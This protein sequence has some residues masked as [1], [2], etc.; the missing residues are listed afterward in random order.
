MSFGYQVLGFGTSTAA[1]GPTVEY[2]GGYSAGDASAGSGVQTA[3][4]TKTGD[5]VI[6]MGGNVNAPSG[7]FAQGMTG[8]TV[9][10]IGPAW[11]SIY[12]VYLFGGIRRVA[13]DGEAYPTHTGLQTGQYGVVH[14]R[15]SDP[16]IAILGTDA[17]GG[18]SAG[19][20][21]AVTPTVT[22]NAA[23]DSTANVKAYI[24][25]GTSLTF[26]K[27]GTRSVSQTMD[28]FGTFRSAGNSDI[29]FG[30]VCYEKEDALNVT[31]SGG[32][33]TNRDQNQAGY[34]PAFGFLIKLG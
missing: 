1:G 26:N 21:S 30:V 27:A 16:D 10:L 28:K 31:F 9:S 5:I 32:Y 23:N 12:K 18:G 33:S 3:V 22:I 14:L 24:V 25:F 29:N 2:I 7:N 34:T 19:G 4:A 17:F 11:V 13:S 20:T 15:P 6:F 8:P